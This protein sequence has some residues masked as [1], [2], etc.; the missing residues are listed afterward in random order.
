MHLLNMSSVPRVFFFPEAVT[1]NRRI[2]QAISLDL[3]D[4]K[5]KKK[6]Q[7]SPLRMNCGAFL[8]ILKCFQFSHAGCNANGKV[9]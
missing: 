2:L 4:V 5:K 6:K 3:K 7:L 8:K 9:H 1:V